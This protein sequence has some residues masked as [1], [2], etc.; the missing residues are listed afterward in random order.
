MLLLCIYYW[1]IAA[2]FSNTFVAQQHQKAK[3]VQRCLC[4]KGRLVCLLLC[5]DYVCGGGLH[6]Q[7]IWQCRLYVAAAAAR[8]EKTTRPARVPA[9]SSSVDAEERLG[10]PCRSNSIISTSPESDRPTSLPLKWPL[11]SSEC[12]VLSGRMSA[13]AHSLHSSFFGAVCSFAFHHAHS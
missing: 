12:P 13:C 5:R 1:L 6:C 4:P 8:L 2:A 9:C 3:R 10:S 7:A 11:S